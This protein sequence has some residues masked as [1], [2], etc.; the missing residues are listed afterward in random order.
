MKKTAIILL[1]SF[2]SLQFNE[3]AAKN[4]A[5][6]RAQEKAA[7]ATIEAQGKGKTKVHIKTSLGTIVL[8]LYD[9]CPRHQD[10]FIS[11][12]N[13][14]TYTGVIFHRV[15]RDFMIQAGDPTSKYALATATYGAADQGEQIPAEITDKYFHHRGALAAARASDEVNPE[16]MSSS[17]QFYIVQGT[18]RTDEA[19][20]ELDHYRGSKMPEERRNV[21]KTVGGTPHLDGDYTVFG[22]VVKGQK[23]V[24]KISELKTDYNNRPEKDVYIKKITYSR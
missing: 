5:S 3:L 24:E 15:I 21:Y 17:S 12:I 4:K 1:F 13:N 6:E 23:T 16:K 10:N 19:L 8:M 22:R 7:L 2:L 11:H 14:N 20:D 18:G 9:D